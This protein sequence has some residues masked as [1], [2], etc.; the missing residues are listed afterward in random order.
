[1]AD[2]VRLKSLAAQVLAAPWS[3]RQI[4]ELIEIPDRRERRTPRLS[5]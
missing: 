5:P 1:M 3:A 4:A 2:A